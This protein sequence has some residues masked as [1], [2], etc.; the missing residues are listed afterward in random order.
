VIIHTTIFR[1]HP[2]HVMSCACAFPIVPALCFGTE[3]ENLTLLS[4]VLAALVAFPTLL[5]A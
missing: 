5:F 1:A 2:E 4:A 3:G